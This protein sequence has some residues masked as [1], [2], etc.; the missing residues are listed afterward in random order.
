MSK[1]IGYTLTKSKGITTKQWVLSIDGVIINL[2]IGCAV[3]PARE[4]DY[5]QVA[6]L[7]EKDYE[8]LVWIGRT[9]RPIR[10]QSEVINEK[11]MTVR[12]TAELSMLRDAYV[13]AVTPILT[14]HNEK[15]ATRL[16]RRLKDVV[17][18]V[19]SRADY[20]SFWEDVLL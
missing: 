8:Q 2:A 3:I 19:L 14:A 7:S 1:T 20:L 10:L 5:T 16:R 15:E 18:R 9:Y 13:K 11:D 6:E 17:K 12:A 4:E